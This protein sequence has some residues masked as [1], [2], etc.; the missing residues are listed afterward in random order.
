M[1]FVANYVAYF[2][3]ADLKRYTCR[4]RFLVYANTTT[5]FVPYAIESANFHALNTHTS[6]REREKYRKFHQKCRNL[7][8]LVW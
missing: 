6:G 8:P 4:Q 5:Y 2:L 7:L 1:I 3:A